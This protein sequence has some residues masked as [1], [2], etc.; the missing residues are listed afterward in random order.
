M[1]MRFFRVL[2]PHSF[3]IYFGKIGARKTERISKN[4]TYV[5]MRNTTTVSGH[6]AIAIFWL[7][8]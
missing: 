4:A 2:F 1:M 5:S 7:T 3:G 8:N 6:F